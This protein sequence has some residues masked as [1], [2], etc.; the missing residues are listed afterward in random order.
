MIRCPANI[1]PGRL[2]T[3]EVRLISFGKIAGGAGSTR[4]ERSQR[5]LI[6][7]GTN[8][9]CHPTQTRLNLRTL[10]LVSISHPM[11]YENGFDFTENFDGMQQY[12]A[13][14]VWVNLKSL[15]GAGGSQ[16][17]TLRDQCYRFV[18]AQLQ[19]L[20]KT[21]NEC[22]FANILDG[23]IAALKKKHFDYLLGLPEYASAR[24]HIYVG[25]LKDY[26]SWLA[27]RFS[28]NRPL[29]RAFLRKQK[30]T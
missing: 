19:Y 26:F 5:L 8:R 13:G 29:T 30:N 7:L 9:T 23:D 12:D 20:V 4:P 25:D 22:Y 11:K 15:A 6:E 28:K 17:R 27:A 2:M 10:T 21:N 18:E 3:K 24:P 16:T 14:T 1:L